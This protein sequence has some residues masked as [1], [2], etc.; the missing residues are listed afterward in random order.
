[1]LGATKMLE[2][3]PGYY[4]Q[5]LRENTSPCE[6]VISRDI[7]RTFPKHFLFDKNK[8][9]GQQSLMNVLR[10]YSLHDPEVGY[11]QGMGFVSALFLSYMP[12]EVSAS[13]YIYAS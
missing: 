7:G 13:E 5:L 4:E 9:L 10:A 3:N 1:M 2:N 11:C 12:E 8:S 6:E